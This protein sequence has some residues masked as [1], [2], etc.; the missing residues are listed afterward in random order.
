MSLEDLAKAIEVA[1]AP[2]PIEFMRAKKRILELVSDGERHSLESLLRALTDIEGL[3]TG[4]ASRQGIAVERREDI[5]STVRPDLPPIR[6]I[7]L[8]NAAA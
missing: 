2:A 6:R 7:A 5:E 1:A 4:D 3:E 8:R